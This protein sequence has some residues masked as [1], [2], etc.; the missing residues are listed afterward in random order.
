MYYIIE[1]INGYDILDIEC[2]IIQKLGILF[3]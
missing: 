3:E 1:V 2:Q